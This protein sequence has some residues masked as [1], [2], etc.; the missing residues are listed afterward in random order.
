MRRFLVYYY[1]VYDNTFSFIYVFFLFFSQV[2]S[3][4]FEQDWSIRVLLM[5]NETLIYIYMDL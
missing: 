4:L 1:I 2:F 3:C 5:G